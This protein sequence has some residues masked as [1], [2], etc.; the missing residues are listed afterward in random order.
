LE[1]SPRDYTLKA[2]NAAPLFQHPSGYFREQ[3]IMGDIDDSEERA[4]GRERADRLQAEHLRKGREFTAWFE[5][6]YAGAGGD[7]ALI[8]WADLKPHP[9][10]VAHMRKRGGP[11]CAKRALDVGCG[12]GD[13]A[14]FLAASGY[15]VTAIDLSPSAIAWAQRR[16]GASGVDF[17]VANLLEP[18][19]E[20]EG[21]FDFVNEIYTIQS[22][23]P[24][25]RGRVIAAIASLLAPGGRLHLVCRSRPDDV[26][27][28]EGPPWP[29][30]RLELEGFGRAG[31][32]PLSFSAFDEKRTDGRVIPH[33][34]A[35][36]ER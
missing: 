22:L 32:R 4:R 23:P 28:P 9:A 27:S 7:A 26:T 17:R 25:L 11:S 8:P 31:L 2:D 34:I 19:E 36:Y 29:L 1:E 24:E 3:G 5:E 6:L 13:N 15:D 10:L 33:F 16:H 14:A 35:E 30:S 20:L 18:P 21:A 12:L